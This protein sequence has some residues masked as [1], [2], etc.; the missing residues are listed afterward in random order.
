MK[1]LF[2]QDKTMLRTEIKVQIKEKPQG[3]KEDV[4]SVVCMEI[5]K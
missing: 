2:Q 1:W 4:T 5:R 3:L